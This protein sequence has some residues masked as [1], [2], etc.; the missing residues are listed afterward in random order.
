MSLGAASP[1]CDLLLKFFFERFSVISV[2]SCSMSLVAASGSGL[3][4][5][6]IDGKRVTE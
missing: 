3:R 6:A 4:I 2:C 1:R 5:S